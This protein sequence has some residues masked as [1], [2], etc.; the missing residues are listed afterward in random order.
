[1]RLLSSARV[2]IE[3][4][5][6]ELSPRLRRARHLRDSSEALAK[7][8]AAL[9]PEIA[10]K[11]CL[12]V[13]SAPDL[14][15]PDMARIGAVICVNGSGITAARLGLPVPALTVTTSALARTKDRSFRVETIRQ[16]DGLETRNL[17]LTW[18]DAEMH[19]QALN[20]FQKA[21][22]RPR[23]CFTLSDDERAA[24]ALAVMPAENV[25]TRGNDKI[26]TGIFAA[27]VAL[28][29]GAEQVIMAGFSLAGGHSYTAQ[30]T[31]RN[32]IGGDSAFFALAAQNGWPV[33]TTAK[34]LHDEFGLKLEGPR[35][36][37]D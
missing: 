27:T 6:P 29:A 33:S 1:M 8:K 18:G 17:L 26:S 15:L 25:L 31:Y 21:G 13:G 11:R 37:C 20:T 9:V 16:F 5:A 2:A 7:L 23:T 35:P 14:V 12:L 30:N 10:G 22:Y 4:L 24:L 34:A 3:R 32:H 36:P 28:W 19:A